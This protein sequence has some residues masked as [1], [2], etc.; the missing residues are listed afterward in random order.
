MSLRR[1]KQPDGSY[2]HEG[3]IEL[4]EKVIDDEGKLLSTPCCGAFADHSF[5]MQAKLK[6]TVAH[7]MCHRG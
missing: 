2:D 6:N 5:S 4:S 1:I 7:E 3:R